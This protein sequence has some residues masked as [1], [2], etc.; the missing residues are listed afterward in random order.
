MMM[1]TETETMKFIKNRFE[2]IIFNLFPFE[3]SISVHILSV[4]GRD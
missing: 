2:L 3:P 1:E 4:Q